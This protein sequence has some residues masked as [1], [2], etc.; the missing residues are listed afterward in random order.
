VDLAFGLESHLP[1][2]PLPRPIASWLRRDATRPVIGFNVSGLIFNRREDS[3]RHYGLRA[4]YRHAVIR[5]LKRVLRQTDAVVLLVPHVVTRPGHFE[6][7]PDACAAAIEELG[8]LA[9]GR[10]AL[11]A[12]G[13]DPCETKWIISQSDWF[14]GT[15]MHAAIAALSTGVPAAAIA[16]SDK[17]RGVFE[18]CRM[19]EHVADP[20]RLDT[21][22]VVEHLW[23]SWMDRRAAQATLENAL[24]AVFEQAESQMDDIL[25]RCG[26]DVPQRIITPLR[27]AA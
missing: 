5:F 15:R 7:D 25:G 21:D 22:D 11:L 20:R 3:G 13:Y 19:A 8:F 27:K 9:D 10:V 4:D 16:Y 17:T 1:T 18:T 12:E 26:V 24:P 6:H 14:C 23:H 2:G